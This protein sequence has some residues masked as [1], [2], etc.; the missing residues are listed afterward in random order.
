MLLMPPKQADQ[1]DYAIPI[2]SIKGRLKHAGDPK[3]VIDKWMEI[4]QTRPDL[5]SKVVL[6]EGKLSFLNFFVNK[7]RYTQLVLQ[8]IYDQGSSFIFLLI[9]FSYRDIRR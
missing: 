4:S 9:I 8:A 3:E 1:A 2:P 5:I 6:G 7:A